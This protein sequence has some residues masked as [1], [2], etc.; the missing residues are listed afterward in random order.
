MQSIG[1]KWKGEFSKRWAISGL[2]AQTGRPS[3]SAAIAA[4][5]AKAMSFCTRVTL[6][7]V[8]SVTS[9]NTASPGSPLAEP[10]TMVTTGAAVVA[11]AVGVAVT[12]G[13]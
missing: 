1:M 4:S 10:T 2:T 3:G 13:V 7:A 6:T 9:T 12:I 5:G 11:V 8:C